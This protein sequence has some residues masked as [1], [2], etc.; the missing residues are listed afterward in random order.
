MKDFGLEKLFKEIESHNIDNSSNKI[1]IDTEYYRR[2]ILQNHINTIEGIKKVRNKLIA[3]TAEEYFFN[4]YHFEGVTWN[5]IE[6][7]LEQIKP[8][9]NDYFSE[10]K[11]VYISE[12]EYD[13]GAKITQKLVLEDVGIYKKGELS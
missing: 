12:P 13:H 11:G 9:I 10:Y 5:K 3:H 4:T 2:H 1:D 8:L 7:F 6:I